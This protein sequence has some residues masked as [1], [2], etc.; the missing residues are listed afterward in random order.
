[1]PAGGATQI[2]ALTGW[3]QQEDVRR[4]FEAGFNH[5]LVKPLDIDRLWEVIRGARQAATDQAP[6]RSE[7][8]PL[9]LRT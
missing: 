6:G 7:D 3:G 1:M 8:R 4:S 2:I 5:H 9:H